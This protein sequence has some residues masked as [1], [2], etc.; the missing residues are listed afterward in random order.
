[1]IT[2]SIRMKLGVSVSLS[3]MLAV[4]A[5]DKDT[6]TASVQDSASEAPYKVRI[7]RP[8]NASG[9]DSSRALP[10]VA[11]SL[12]FEMTGFAA[13]AEGKSGAEQKAAGS[14]AA[15][16]DGLTKAIIEA[17]RGRGQSF[18]DFTVKIGPRLTIT[19]RPIGDGY[20]VQATL[21]ARGVDT[22]FIVRNGVLQ[23]PPHELKMLRQV[24][25]ETNGEFELLTTRWE[26]AGCEAKVACYLPAGLGTSFA[27]QAADETEPAP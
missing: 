27:G 25:E 24:F 5:C 15:A 3:A 19:H 18:E 8:G 20:E 26:A 9:V 7:E 10:A 22:T 14:Q 6:R 1:M 23:H 16:I 11:R 21:I 4:A 12:A 17:R 2:K 13:N